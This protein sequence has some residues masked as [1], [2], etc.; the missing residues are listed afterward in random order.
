MPELEQ[1]K[2]EIIE[3]IKKKNQ[4]IPNDIKRKIKDEL[5][6]LGETEGLFKKSN[7]EEFYNT[8]ISWKN[9]KKESTDVNKING[10]TPYY[11]EITTKKPE[12]GFLEARRYFA[13]VGFPDIDTD[14]DDEFRDK[15]YDYIIEKYGRENVGNIGT[16]GK[17]KFKS[18]IRRVGKA[19]D[20]AD[21]W[22]ET[23]EDKQAYITNN[24]ARV[25]EIINTFPEGPVIKVRD[26]EG[27]MKIITNV[28]DALIYCDEF[29]K[30]ISKHEGM[31]NYIKQ[32]QGTFATFSS[33]AAG[34]CVSDIPIGMIAPLRRAKKDSYSTQYPNED[35][36]SLGL[37]KFDI[38]AI[39]TLTVIKK[40]C[41]LIADNYDIELDY[42]NLPMGDK[43]ALDIYRE[44][45]LGGV[46]Q[47]E[48]WGMQQTMKEIGV[49]SFRDVMA[50]IALYRPGPMDNIPEY[51]ARKKGRQ[52][53]DYFHKTIE[54]FVKE[55]L[56]ETYGILIYQEQLMRICET[57]AGFSI[58][59]GYVMIKAIGKKIPELM[60]SFEKQFIQGCVDNNVPQGVAHQYWDKF[61][62][63]FANYGFN[64]AHAGAYA[65]LSYQCAYLK[66]NYP[67]EFIITLL[68]V[69]AERSHYEK[70]EK[71]E[72]EFTKKMKIKFL[73]R[74]LNDCGVEYKIENS[75][76]VSK[77]IN[78]T[79][80]RPSLLCKSVGLKSSENIEKNSP[81]S[82]LRDL[83]ERTNFSSVTT[84]VIGGLI[85]AGFFKGKSGIKKKE[86][87]I[88]DFK[89]IRDD[90]KLAQKKGVES[91]DIF[92]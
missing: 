82:D 79:T 76:D 43:K 92:G 50:A 53:I 6:I 66:A 54:P 56:E 17:L 25:S 74:T 10:W 72:K 49:D 59:E 14:F 12:N 22:G 19:L 64:K 52:E 3:D 48:Q 5:D 75:K 71:F 86:S 65:Y 81:Y 69:E 57:L 83:A 40:T 30:E 70:A 7:L 13:R 55:H 23:K 34:I 51:C 38:L 28:D 73:P 29:K 16:H 45:N 18:C 21:S 9:E 58:A 37:I 84:E 39:A 62:V 8:W 87:I 15:I 42:K 4:D 89:T 2:K 85:E 91:V 1:I 26:E 47:C 60:A 46:F 88:F 77:G 61:I 68:N 80:I 33:H 67:E 31:A 11:L 32:I 78:Q 36:E 27:D 44:G 90:L 41:K 20:I 35:L 63:P 24:E